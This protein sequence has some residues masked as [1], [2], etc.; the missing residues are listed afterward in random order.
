MDII[1]RTIYEEPRRGD[2]SDMHLLCQ[3]LTDA[4]K[5]ITVSPMTIVINVIS[6]GTHSLQ[7]ELDV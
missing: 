3:T 1:D 5:S 4:I 2:S 7:Y 6:P